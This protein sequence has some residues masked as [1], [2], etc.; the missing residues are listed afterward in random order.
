MIN[1]LDDYVNWNVF[2]KRNSKTFAFS[3]FNIEL[4]QKNNNRSTIEEFT[5]AMTRKL[6]DFKCFLKVYQ[7]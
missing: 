3:N 6:Y 5:N 1:V 2:E 4:D 7:Y